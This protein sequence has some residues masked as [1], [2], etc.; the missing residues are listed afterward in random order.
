MDNLGRIRTRIIPKS[1]QL[2]SL[3]IPCLLSDTEHFFLLP[4]DAQCL[5]IRLFN[6]VR[7]NRW[8]AVS[9][10]THYNLQLTE[11][12]DQLSAVKV[13]SID[14]HN[15]IRPRFGRLS[16]S[17][18]IDEWSKELPDIIQECSFTLVRTL[19]HSLGLKN[20]FETNLPVKEVKAKLI[21]YLTQQRTLFSTAINKCTKTRR[22]IATICGQTRWH[23]RM[24]ALAEPNFASHV[25]ASSTYILLLLLFRRFCSTLSDVRS[26]FSS[27]SSSLLPSAWSNLTVAADARRYW[28]PT[29][30][31][32]SATPGTNHRYSTK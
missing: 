16:S 22:K 28:T 1:D 7:P 15:L 9:Q 6:R 21:H 11:A 26:P 13:E 20:N 17:L 18:S 19:I 12:I 29:V 3:D 14:S 10:L 25:F 8:F 5:F 24:V 23:L 27:P 31:Q 2:P 4:F 30:V 32:E